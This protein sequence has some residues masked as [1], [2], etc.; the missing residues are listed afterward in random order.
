MWQSVSPCASSTRPCDGF[1]NQ[2]THSADLPDVRLTRSTRAV[3]STNGYATLAGVLRVLQPGLMG[4]LGVSA[5]L[6][7]YLII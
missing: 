2:G 5:A 4:Y 6:L 3:H 1:L 7:L